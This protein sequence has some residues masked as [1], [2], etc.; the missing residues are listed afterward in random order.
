MCASCADLSD[1][2]L[3]VV[4]VMAVPPGALQ[5]ISK[6]TGM[7]NKALVDGAEADDELDAGDWLSCIHPAPWGQ[8][9]VHPSLIVP[10]AHA[11]QASGP[12]TPY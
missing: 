10:S 6:L 7:Q 2:P 3:S 11:L 8:H 12:N 9:A 5:V 1:T 4:Q